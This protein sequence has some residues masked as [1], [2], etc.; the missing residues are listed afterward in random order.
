MG[1]KEGIDA[2][3]VV[4]ST[5]VGKEEEGGSDRKKESECLAQKTQ[6]LRRRDQRGK[7]VK[8]TGG[9]VTPKVSTNRKSRHTNA[10]RGDRGNH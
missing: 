4:I 8:A 6:E 2:N 1:K 3:S 9:S 7:D 10:R 5:I